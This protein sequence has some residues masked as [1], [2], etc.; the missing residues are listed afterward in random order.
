M[1]T[2]ERAY[3]SAPEQ[4][5]AARQSGAT[6][7]NLQYAQPRLT[8][9]PPS[10]G[11]LEHLEV[12]TVSTHQ[13]TTLPDCLRRLTRLR[14]LTARYCRLT[15]LPEW[16]GELGQL[17][18]LSV[19]DN[20]LTSLPESLGGLT[21]LE[22]LNAGDNDLATLPESLRRLTGLRRLDLRSTKMSVMPEWL[23]AL[24]ELR[25]LDLSGN[26]LGVVPEWLRA[27][28][29]LETLKFAGN[30]I[31]SL[32]DWLGELER[33]ENLNLGFN[34]LA[35][36]PDSVADL[37]RLHDVWLEDNPL[38]R[39]PGSLRP[40]HS[41][42][43]LGLHA[44]DL[45]SIPDWIGELQSLTFIGLRNNRLTDL[46]T[47]INRLRGLE[48]VYLGGNAIAR[49][50]DALGG[51]KKLRMLEAA[52]CRLTEL[53]EW[54]PELES[55]TDLNIT[56]NPLNPELAAAAQEGLDAIKRYLR[57]K[58]QAE[59][60]LNEAK[61]ILVGEGGVGKSSLLAALRGDPWD[62]DRSTTHGIE[63]KPV[64]VNDPETGTEI[65]LNGWDFGGQ[66]V[67]RPTHQLF[68]SAPAVYL[69]VWKPRE[70]PQQG[71][72]TEWISLVTHREPDAKIFVVATHAG[73]GATQPDIDRQALWDR[74]GKETVVGFAHVDC[75]PAVRDERTGTWRGE[76]AGIS[77]LKEALARAAARLPGVGRSVP[78][79]WHRVRR[80]L[81]A[82]DSAY[83]PLARVVQAC[84]E[85]GMDDE[86][87]HDFVRN[88]RR[89]G[90]LIHYEHDPTLRD[91]VV[92][93]PD[94]LATA[95]SFA[96][97][98]ANT[99]RNRGLVTFRRLGE[100]WN[101]RTRAPEFRYPAELHRVFLRLMERFDLSYP[102]PGTPLGGEPDET[103]LIAQ[104]VPDNRP[105]PMR[106][107]PPA[108]A[109]GDNEQIQICRIVDQRNR[110]STSAE[111]LFYRLIVRL[112]GYSLGRRDYMES[113]H[114]QRGLVLEDD[115]GARA[116]LEH[117]GHDVRITVRSPYPAR[118]LSALTDEVKWLVEHFWAGL[119]CDLMVP[120]LNP[121]PCTG[122]FAVSTL[123]ENKDAHPE[124]PCPI[125][126]K[127]QN[128]ERLLQNAPDSRPDPLDELLPRAGESARALEEIRIQSRAYHAEII[129]RF[130][131]LDAS[132]RALASKVED[133][134]TGLMRTLI[135]DAKD[136]PRLF[137]FEPVDPG[138]LGR[139]AWISETFRITLWCEH[140][141]LPLPALDG[142]GSA[143]GVYELA[144]PR[145]WFAKA[146]P[147]LRLLTTTLSLVVPLASSATKLML[148][149]TSYKGIE[150]Q[151]DFGQKSFDSILKGSEKAGAWLARDDAPDVERGDAIEARGAVLRQLHA[152]LKERDP[153]FGGLVRVQNKRHEFLWVDPRF[154]HEY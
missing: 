75:R 15:T 143:R 11:E 74:F 77:S 111:G 33:L 100:L 72:V 138:F 104:L 9:L 59:V 148:D 16:L 86:E 1:A 73:P 141:R 120:C 13:L 151:L 78:A 41:L 109:A 70:G 66:Q 22:T 8:D 125:C 25:F 146:A 81:E 131:R 119:R 135:D 126:N 10:L 147:F 132:S 87:A 53:P 35:T 58:S 133:A 38:G 152:W 150:K 52:R 37:R 122:L 142:N 113:V 43:H 39:V 60:V 12:L 47:S 96:L 27:L 83:L 91:T 54:L 50:P 79:R 88:S 44:C 34:R 121:K 89:L 63:I 65:T 55:L 90:R 48:T 134:F 21:R 108:P 7:L 85:L 76:C 137:S 92:L 71:L 30:E 14:T 84:R 149:E 97:D 61:L 3:G 127:W 20:D 128:I 154:E 24:R 129:G 4:I 40:L 80:A 17:E 28:K 18:S 69:V 103:S 98:D 136:G 144:V 99:R 82:T 112:H 123:V 45:D 140:S 36:V 102:V 114:W 130:D 31:A 117:V 105:D 2:V 42:E 68:F 23:R 5:E 51:L 32:P 64:K 29:Q 6:E 153:G 124:Q 115:Y 94:W 93:K 67:Y 101:H 57:A 26:K 107:W 110:E 145:E 118:F 106:A 56:D 95:I 49:L 19:G 62:G 46:P 116:L 139:P